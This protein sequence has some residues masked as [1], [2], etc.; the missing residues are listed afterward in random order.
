MD[1]QLMGGGGLTNSKYV[2]LGGDA[3]EGTIMCQTYHPS[4]TAKHIKDFTEKFNSKYG[5][6]PDPNAAQSYDAIMILGQAMAKVG[7][8]DKAKLRDE[9]AATKG[10]KGV[11]GSV[12]F[13]STGDSP[14][15]MMVIQI[16]NGK[17]TLAE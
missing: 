15:D 16:Q 6:N 7:V 11:T 9:I 2:E 3:T 8:E 17:Y 1:V 10:F 4:S 13:D 5:R 12:G 14:R